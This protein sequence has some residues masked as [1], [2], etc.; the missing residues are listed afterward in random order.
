MLFQVQTENF[1]AM[2]TAVQDT[3]SAA[4]A[5]A[6]VTENS[7]QLFEMAKSGGWIM[8][9]LAIM[10]AF[11]I[12]LFLERLV[13]LVKAT[14]EDKT[15]MIPYYEIG[16]DPLCGWGFDITDAFTGEHLGVQKEFIEA[17]V[18]AGDCKVFTGTLVKVR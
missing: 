8:V 15:F 4:I 10:L 11:A 6:V 2:S 3:V 9:V 17:R 12:Y 14:K 5:D 1:D 7:I 16:L 18:P 13:V